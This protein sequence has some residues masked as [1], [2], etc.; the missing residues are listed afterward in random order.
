MIDLHLLEF[1]LTSFPPRVLVL[2]QIQG[3]LEMQL[4]LVP[5][6]WGS[7]SLPLLQALSPLGVPPLLQ[8]LPVIQQVPPR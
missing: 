8:L 5:L 6:R 1:G 3:L 2:V 4:R 7:P